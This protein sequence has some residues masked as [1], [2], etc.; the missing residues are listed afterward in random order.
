MTIYAYIRVSTDDKKQTTEAQKTHIT[1]AGFAVDEWFAEDG[2]SG[3]VLALKRP[4]FS[5]MMSKVKEGDTV[6]CT[7]IDRLGR[8]AADTMTTI[9]TF[10]KIKVH[11]RVMQLD[12]LDLTSSA[13]KLIVGVL[14]CVAE[15]ER[16]MN[17]ERTAQGI[18]N[19]RQKGVKLG[20]PLKVCPAVL[21]E[22]VAGES[23]TRD[24]AQRY[25]LSYHTL[26]KIVLKWRGD[27][28]GYQKEWEQRQ[29]QYSKSA[30]AN[31]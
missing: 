4:A 18:E 24:V 30:L 3:T 15:M 1:G 9:K 27:V 19:A 26:Q 7:M 31:Q 22:C 17:S 2:M 10:T 21:Q 23:N 25:N 20:Q 28:E 13:G 8:D 14:A 29:L 5:A 6:I 12:G 16:N 11:L